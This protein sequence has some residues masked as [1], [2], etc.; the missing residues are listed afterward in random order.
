MQG[1]QQQGSAWRQ[2]DGELTPRGPP[3]CVM[4]RAASE[5]VTSPADSH[6]DYSHDRAECQVRWEDLNS[7]PV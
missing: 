7:V 5:A 1:G 2:L 6:E 3:A 4:P